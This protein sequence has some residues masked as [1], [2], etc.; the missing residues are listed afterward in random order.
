MP[1]LERLLQVVGVLAIAC[2]VLVGS[3][4]YVLASVDVVA[5]LAGVF[6]AFVGVTMLAAGT[7]LPRLDE[8]GS[9]RA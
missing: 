5:I 6:V 3:Y 8:T 1:T 7:V 9:R 4:G 2:G